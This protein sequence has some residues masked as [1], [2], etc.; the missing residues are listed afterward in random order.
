MIPKLSYNTARK[1]INI[2]KPKTSL[3]II[4]PCHST[5]SSYAIINEIPKNGISQASIINPL[6]SFTSLNRLRENYIKDFE[7]IEKTKRNF[8]DFIKEIHVKKSF[9]PEVIKIEKE[10]KELGTT[11]HLEDDLETGKTLLP[12]LK[13][14]KNKKLRLPN[15]IY[16]ITSNKQDFQ[17]AT[18]VLIHEGRDLTPIFLR[19]NIIDPKDKSSYT[20]FKSILFHELGHYNHLFT[21]QDKITSLMIF[22]KFVH[23]FSH[24]YIAKHLCFNSITNKYG[25]EFVA[26]VFSGLM[27][28]LKFPQPI[29]DCYKALNGPIIG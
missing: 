12:L 2:S 15:I 18:P 6:E 10:I 3:Q 25:E 8:S 9:N 27:R 4:N 23:Q 21:K 26:D 22:D 1:L 11:I 19:K 20:F 24:H 28:G 7:N 29:M 17:G 13:E 14:A 5:Q 16:F